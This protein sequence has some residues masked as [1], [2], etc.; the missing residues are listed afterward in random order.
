M[1]LIRRILFI[2][3]VLSVG[4]CEA[5]NHN[6]D[7]FIR[8]ASENSPVIKDFQNQILISRIDSQILKASLR[9]QVNFLN[10]N[11]YAPVINGW[12][13]D[14]A[15]TNYANLTAI[16]Q[17]NRN[18]VTANNLAVQ[19]RTIDLQRRALLDTIQLSVR[20][21]RRTITEQYITAFGDLLAV[22]FTREVFD[23]MKKEEEML[24]KLTE[25]N[26]FK[27]T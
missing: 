12:G 19:L 17:A 3:F 16:V 2:S 23:L 20:D 27:Q 18:F 4:F 22:D 13:Y 25:A 8:V 7:Y 11:S 14:P 6:L 15:I 9:T 24:K 21:L 5:Q 10:T 26:V 1:A